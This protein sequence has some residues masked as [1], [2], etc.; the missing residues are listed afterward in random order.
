MKG[1][2]ILFRGLPGSGK[3]SLAA[4]LCEKVYSADMYFEDMD[5][6]GNL[7]YNFKPEKLRE[8]HEW[9]QKHTG[10]AMELRSA[11]TIGVANT[12]TQEW[13]MEAY[14]KLAKEHGYR[15]STVIVENRHGGVNIHGVPEE[16]ITQMENR[17]EI[18]L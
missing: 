16:K 14:F 3:S 6:A 5:E 10:L 12:F 8:A 17:F 1:N 18:K 11:K 15:V 7:V 9:C 4:A 13:E 2:L